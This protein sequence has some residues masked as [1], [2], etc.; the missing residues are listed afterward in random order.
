MHQPYNVREK[1]QARLTKAILALR[2][3]NNDS[4]NYNHADSKISIK[5]VDHELKHQHNEFTTDG[6]KGLTSKDS[7]NKL[8]ILCA[9][10]LITWQ[11]V[12]AA[13]EKKAIAKEARMGKSADGTPE[14]DS[15][16]NTYEEADRQNISRLAAIGAKEG[17][18]DA[19]RE[20]IGSAI[21]DPILETSDSSESKTANQIELHFLLK[22]V[23]NAAERPAVSDALNEFK[24]FIATRFDFR[25]KLVNDV[26]Q[27]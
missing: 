6:M 27:L 23:L 22:T 9:T 1:S 8:F 25:G 19:I 26:E 21:T 16:S 7:T 24:A 4:G 15:T 10:V 13:S 11:A 12:T 20:K 5:Q 14:I 18:I 2:L 3:K 17:G